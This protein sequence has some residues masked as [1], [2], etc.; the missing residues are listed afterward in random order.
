MSGNVDSLVPYKFIEKLKAL[1][2][3][4]AIYLY[5]SRARGDHMERSDIDL[6]IVCPQARENEWSAVLDIIEQADTLLEIDCVRFDRITDSK[7]ASRIASQKVVLFERK[8][9][10]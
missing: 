2:F 4:D 6:A 9:H 5:G 10:A 1:P 3:V 8:T 7:F